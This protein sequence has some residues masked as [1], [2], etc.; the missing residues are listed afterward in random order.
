MGVAR[1]FIQVWLQ[2]P[3]MLSLICYAP[4]SGTGMS[5]P[6]KFRLFWMSIN[7]SFL[8]GVPL[9]APQTYSDLCFFPPFFFLMAAFVVYGSSPQTRGQIWA[10][11]E[12]YVAATAAQDLSR[13][14]NLHCS[15]WQLRI[16]NPLPKARDGTHILMDTICVG[17][18]TCWPLFFSVFLFL[19]SFFFLS[20]SLLFLVNKAKTSIK[21]QVIDASIVIKMIMLVLITIPCMPLVFPVCKAFFFLSFFFF[22]YT[23]TAYGSSQAKG[24]IR[25][26]AAGLHHSHSNVGSEPSLWPTPQLT[27]RL[28]PQPTDLGQELNLHPH[29]Y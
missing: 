10:A 29:G 23:P 26:T 24:Q 2:F 17:F 9:R 28:D 16:L 14:C 15:L 20:L 27:A 8:W 4:N 12:A 3:W 19:L 11:A 25:A 22:R 21:S 18:L 6:I 1:R 13:I 7:C 5:D